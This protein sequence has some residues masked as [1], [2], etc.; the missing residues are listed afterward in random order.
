VHPLL[1]NPEELDKLSFFGTG[2][3]MAGL[4]F[5]MANIHNAQD[6]AS[7]SRAWPPP[8]RPA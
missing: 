4:A 8:A 6:L 7:S 5:G 1:S 2:M 3:A